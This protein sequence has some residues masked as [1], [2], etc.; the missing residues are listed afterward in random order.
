MAKA[1]GLKNV[2]KL[3]KTMVCPM[4][5][6]DSTDPLF[7]P[8]CVFYMRLGSVEVNQSFFTLTVRA[9]NITD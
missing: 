7:A 4:G 6:S 8:L 2:S 1:G 9:S 3:V 5:A